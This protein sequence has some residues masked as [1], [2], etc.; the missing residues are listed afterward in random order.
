VCRHR[1]LKDLPQMSTLASTPYTPMSFD[2]KGQ[3]CCFIMTGTLHLNSSSYLVTTDVMG[4]CCGL[5]TT[6]CIDL[7]YGLGTVC[8]VRIHIPLEIRVVRVFYHSAGI[9]SRGC[10]WHVGLFGFVILPKIFTVCL[11][12]AA[13]LVLDLLRWRF[14]KS[15]VKFGKYL[16]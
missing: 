9:S 2:R 1:I 15:N 5:Y 14:S 12:A 10:C 8:Y 3:C 11:W 13:V 7:L 16:Y 4:N 6:K